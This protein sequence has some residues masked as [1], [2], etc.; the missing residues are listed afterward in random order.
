MYNQSDYPTT[1]SHPPLIGFGLD[2]FSIYGR[3]L[4]VSAPGASIALDLCGGHSHDPYGYHYH[5]EVKKINVTDYGQQVPYG[6]PYYVFLPGITNC[7]KKKTFKLFQ[8]FLVVNINR[9]FINE[10]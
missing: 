9:N 6:T 3:Y 4:S 5:T 1:S 8:V 2:G 10:K 7:K